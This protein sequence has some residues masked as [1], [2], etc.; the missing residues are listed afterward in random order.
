MPISPRTAR[1]VFIIATLLLVV[2]FSLGVLQ[3]FFRPAIYALIIAIGCRPLY[4]RLGKR[5]HSPSWAALL[6]VLGVLCAVIVPVL[7]ITALT[8]GEIVNAAHY[9]KAQSAAQGGAPAYIAHVRD[10]FFAW[11]QNYVSIQ[12]L[13][14][15]QRSADLPSRIG[16]RMVGLGKAFAREALNA[17]ASAVL[18]LFILF[19]LFRDGQ[20][21][22]HTSASLIPLPE[23]RTRKLFK[24]V[25]N[26]IVANLYGILGVAIAQGVLMTI[27]L[28]IAG[29]GS[30]FLLGMLTS[31]CSVIPVVGT[32][33]VWGPAAIYLFM[34][35]HVGKGIFLLIW[36]LVVVSGSDNIIRPLLVFGRVEL[37]PLL[38]LFSLIGG[39][40]QFGF[41]GLFI[42]PVLISLLVALIQVLHDEL[43]GVG[44][45]EDAPAKAG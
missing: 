13:E 24:T 20:K 33:V 16:D 3:P 11:L 1:Y 25:E 12:G 42:G 37:H 45:I 31:V 39:L 44:P 17:T 34:T 4:E 9:L 35:H 43:K 36:G 21:W 14:L 5:V 26:S 30:P 38:L 32:S 40:L 6:M 27:G 15:Q 2:G 18:T 8:G 7:A 19:F 22:L 10:N 41:V 28:L 29:V 23:A